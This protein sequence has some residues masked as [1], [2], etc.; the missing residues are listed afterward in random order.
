[1]IF[2]DIGLKTLLHQGISEPIFYGDL[3]C[4]FKRIVGKPNFSDQCKNMVRRCIGVGYGLGLM[5]QSA[6]L[7]LGPVTVCCYGFLF[8]CAAV[9][10]ASGSVAALAWGFGRWVGAWCLSVA[11]PA[12]ARLGVFFGSGCLWVVGP[13]LCF[14]VECWFGWGVFRGGALRWLGGLRAG[15]AFLVLRRQRN[16]GRGFGAGGVHL[17]PPVAWAA[18]RSGA[19]VLLL[20]AFCLLLL[21]LW[22]SVIVLCFVVRCFV[23][24]LVLQSSWW[25]GGLVALLGLSSWCL[26]V[27]GRLFLAVPRG[28]LQFVIVVFPDHTH[29]LF[30]IDSRISNNQ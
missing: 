11:G 10:R 6:C 23:S 9:G 15:W 1:M 3:V 4:K 7:V 26:V 30:S 14:V 18:V 29:L 25:G 24:V 2:K 21:P 16:L 13:F 19:V 12:V 17:G 20:L 27:V 5:R 28:C 8:S 22:E